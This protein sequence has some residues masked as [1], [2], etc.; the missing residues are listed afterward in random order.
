MKKPKIN[1][2]KPKKSKNRNNYYYSSKTRIILSIDSIYKLNDIQN[3]YRIF[4][5]IQ[6]KKKLLKEKRLKPI[7]IKNNFFTKITV[8]ENVLM[9]NYIFYKEI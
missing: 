6:K 9:K 4:K 3:S 7:N 1:F 8:N 2:L 5:A